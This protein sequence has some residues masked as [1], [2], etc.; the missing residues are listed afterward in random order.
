MTW[1]DVVKSNFQFGPSPDESNFETKPPVLPDKTGN[2]PLPVPGI[3]K[4]L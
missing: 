3:T 2:Y 1:E 4:L